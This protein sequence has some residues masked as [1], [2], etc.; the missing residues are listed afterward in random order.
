MVAKNYDLTPAG[1][2][3]ALDLKRPISEKLVE[4]ATFGGCNM[5][6]KQYSTGCRLKELIQTH[7]DELAQLR[8][9]LGSI[10]GPSYD[11]IGGGSQKWNGDTAETNLVIRCVDLERQIEREMVQMITLMQSIHTTIEAVRNP[12]ERLVLRC[13]YIL[14]LNWDDTA[15]RMNYSPTQVRRLHGSALQNVVVPEEYAGK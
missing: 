4:V 2:I 14:S 8:S 6:A 10:S 15:T 5:T 9:M 7:K 3:K 12:D 13:R 11:K 1:I